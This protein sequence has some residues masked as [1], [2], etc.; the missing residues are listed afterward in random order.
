MKQISTHVSYAEATKSSVAVKYQKD[1]T[2]NSEQLIAMQLLAKTVFEPLREHFKKPIV[3]TSFFRSKPVNALVGGATNSQ[4]TKGEAMDI[5]ADVLGGLTNSEVFYFIKN[6]LTFDQL[7]WEFGDKRNPDWVH[8]S[9]KKS[10]N[11]MQVLQ[12]KKVEHKTLYESWI[13]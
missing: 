8:V 1:N 13:G 9:G 6:R 7:I 12:S 3:I 5:D 4:H 2:P 11:R 10:G